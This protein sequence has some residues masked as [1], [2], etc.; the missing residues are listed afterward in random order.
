MSRP[1][2]TRPM[3]HHTSWPKP[4]YKSCS[5]LQYAVCSWLFFT[6][7]VLR[8]RLPTSHIITWRLSLSFEYLALFWHFSCQLCF[9]NLSYVLFASGLLSFFISAYLLFLSS[10]MSDCVTEWTI[11]SILLS[12]SHFLVP[13]FLHSIF[14][15]WKPNLF[16]SCLLID[17]STL[18]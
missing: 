16:L 6:L 17:L 2:P 13:L 14:S 15:A 12:Y 4:S 1:D 11:P 3:P 18:D 8:G 10:Y 9:T 5:P 7:Y